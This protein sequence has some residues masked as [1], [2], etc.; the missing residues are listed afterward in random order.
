MTHKIA[1]GLV[2]GMRRPVRP[3]VL[4]LR[5]FVQG[6]PAARK[7]MAEVKSIES[8]VAGGRHPLHA[9]YSNAQN[10]LSVFSEIVSPLREFCAF[11]PYT[12]AS[13][14]RV[15]SRQPCGRR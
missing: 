10:Y 13:C 9:A 6:R 1:H 11:A 2:A 8:L 4:K 14:R 3:G 12:G 5:D 15:V 7:L